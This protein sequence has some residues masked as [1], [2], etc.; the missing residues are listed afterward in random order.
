MPNTP[1]PDDNAIPPEELKFS[2]RTSEDVTMFLQ[3]VK[4]AALVQGRQRDDDWQIDYAEACLTGEALRWFS[5]LGKETPNTWA[6][7]RTGFLRRFGAPPDPATIPTSASTAPRAAVQM[8]PLPLKASQI[9]NEDDDVV[10][11]KTLLI[12]DSGVGKTSLVSCYLG[13]EWTPHTLPTEGVLYRMRSGFSDAAGLFEPHM[14]DISGAP[15][16]RDLVAQY[17]VG[18]QDVWIVYDVTD[19]RSFDSVPMWR[20]IVSK[21]FPEMRPR[22]L[23]NKCDLFDKIVVPREEAQHLADEMN[24]NFWQVSVKTRDGMDRL[25]GDWLPEKDFRSYYKR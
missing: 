11:G 2:G 16:Y 25:V 17:V 9:S 6:A 20:Q 21:H 23:G 15:H 18:I 12:G 3:R 4:K 19:R 5:G 22:L 24:M 13:Y 7:L 14:W 1:T 10:I 8:L